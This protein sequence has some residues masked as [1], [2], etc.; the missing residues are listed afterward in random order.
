[1]DPERMA[2]LGLLEGCAGWF[3]GLLLLGVGFGPVRKAL[4]LAGYLLGAA[5]AL[6][7]LASCCASWQ[8]PAYVWFDAGPD[9]VPIG[10]ISGLLSF[11][12]HVGMF[13][14]IIAAG[15]VLSKKVSDQ[16]QGGG[17]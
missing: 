14:L 7:F 13:L 5:G 10:N 8:T 9:M 16:S 15:F 4:P 2:I 6:Q 17:S 1:M 12:S 11:F 3:V